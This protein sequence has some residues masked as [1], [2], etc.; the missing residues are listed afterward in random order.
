MRNLEHTISLKKLNGSW[1][2]VDDDYND[3]LW[4][5]LKSTQMSDE[6]IFA[7]IDTLRSTTQKTQPALP[8]ASNDLSY[9]RNGAIDYA[10]YWY[11][12]R[13]P[14]YYDFSGIGGDCTNFVS[15]AFYIG[16]KMPM[17]FPDTLG[18]GTPGWYYL[19][20]WHRARAWVWV[21]SL[22]DFIVND[23]DNISGGPEG[24]EVDLN[25]AIRGDVIQYERTG[26]SIWDHSVIIV[27]AE[28]IGYGEM[29]YWVA[30]HD[31]D[32]DNYPYT[33]FAYNDVRFIRV[34]GAPGGFVYLPLLINDVSTISQRTSQNP[35][36]G[37]VENFEEPAPVSPYPGP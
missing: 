34:V 8:Q 1:V 13:N 30:S 18:V 9:D 2:I 20:V 37:P 36:P 4:Q 12:K 21:D 25:G 23:P 32:V 28:D 3:Y 22:Y 26:D 6:E 29:M 5:L 33:S 10:H 15:Q 31:D 14:N 27:S 11:D 24:Y 17:G 16:G 7:S 19:D 35:Y